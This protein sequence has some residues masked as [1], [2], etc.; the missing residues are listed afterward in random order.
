M[1]TY[2]YA[3]KAC[4]EHIDVRQ[5]VNDEPLSVCPSCG[6]SLRKVFGSIGIAFKGSGFYRTDSRVLSKDNKKAK[7]EGA[8]SSDGGSETKKDSGSSD[9]GQKSDAK[10]DSKPKADTAKSASTSK[11]DA[12]SA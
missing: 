7:A 6:G 9:G 2:E 4:G 3:C 8:G 5:S 11:P 1:P 10:T 12:K